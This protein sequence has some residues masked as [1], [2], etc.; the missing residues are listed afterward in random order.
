MEVLATWWRVLDYMV[1]SVGLHDG[2]LTWWGVGLHGGSVEIHGGDCCVTWRYW[3][4]LWSVELHDGSVGFHGGV[5][6][7]MVEIVGLQ[8]WSVG[9]YGGDCMVASWGMLG[10]MA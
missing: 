4:T 2:R 3:V 5:L 10:Y 6:G 7:Y 1:E 9:L 8:C